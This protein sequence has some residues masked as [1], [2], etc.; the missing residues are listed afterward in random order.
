LCFS[1][2]NLLQFKAQFLLR[3]KMFLYLL[4]K[5]MNTHSMLKA[6]YISA[7]KKMCR[8]Y[9]SLIR[10]LRVS[11]YIW[12]IPGEFTAKIHNTVKV[13]SRGISF[14][15]VEQNLREFCE[16]R[17]RPAR[18]THPAR[19]FCARFVSKRSEVSWKRK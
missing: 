10:N 11:N 19:T 17:T 5:L 8:L 1:F 13:I 16:T 3:K 12:K 15:A 14:A 4:R 6:V 18:L 2:C 7:I 9:R